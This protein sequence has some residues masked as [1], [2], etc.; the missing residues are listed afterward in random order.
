MGAHLLKKAY[1]GL[2]DPMTKFLEASAAS[3]PLDW[4]IYDFTCYWLPPI[5]E[6]LSIRKVFFSIFNARFLSIIGPLSVDGAW[7]VTNPEILSSPPPWI[8]FPNSTV[9]YMPYEA[10][11]IFRG[12]TENTSSGVSDIF[13]AQICIGSSDLIAVRSC[14][15]LEGE[16]LQL[17]ERLDKKTAVPVG[18]LPPFEKDQE[19][20]T[21]NTIIGWLERQGSGSVVYVALGSEV[22]PSQEQ[23]TELAASSV[24]WSYQIF[25]SSGHLGNQQ[26]LLW[27]FLMGSKSEFKSV[28]WFGRV[29]HLSS[30]Y[31]NM[32]QWE[33]S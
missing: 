25:L 6:K 33:G 10:R 12:I 7:S 26:L 21:W 3:N 22:E 24:V 28:G 15:E 14:W 8:P 17:V 23:L 5:A 16:Y 1:D 11:M 27:S 2:Q 4:I 30:G 13:R 18:L 9:Y 20:E 31:F 19:D 32:I 29:G